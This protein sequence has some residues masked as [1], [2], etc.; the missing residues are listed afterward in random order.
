[1]YR[2][3]QKTNRIIYGAL[4]AAITFWVTVAF[5]G[6]GVDSHH[7]GIMLKTAAELAKGRVLYRDCVSQYG[8]VVHFL[9]SI[10]VSIF[11]AKLKVIIVQ[12]ALVD[13]VTSW[14]IFELIRKYV[15]Q[16]Y[17]FGVCV[18]ILA[19]SYMYFWIYHPWSN[20]YSVCFM[21]LCLFSTINY[22]EKRKG[23]DLIL[24]A[25]WAS[26]TFW[27]KLP[28]GMV[29]Y[30]ALAAAFFVIAVSKER[31]GD[32]KKRL[33]HMGVFLGTTICVWGL[34]VVYLAV[35]GA[36][37]ACWDQMVLF[38]LDFVQITIDKIVLKDAIL[39]KISFP[40]VSFLDSLFICL[41]K[42]GFSKS[43]R[44]YPI[45]ALLGFFIYAIRLLTS[46]GKEKKQRDNSAL[47]CFAI[48]A[49]ASWSQYYPVSCYRHRYWGMMLMIAFVSVVYY[50]ICKKYLKWPAINVAIFAFL[51]TLIPNIQLLNNN[52][53][54]GFEKLTESTN[55]VDN[56]YSVL[57][58]M[59]LSD[60]EYAFYE[61]F[62]NTLT[63][64]REYSGTEDMVNLS[65][66]Y[67][68]S[69]YSDNDYY[70]Y[71]KTLPDIMTYAVEKHAIVVT[72]LPLDDTIY[73]QYTLYASI[74]ITA[75]GDE[76]FTNS[77]LLRFYV[78]DTGR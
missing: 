3:N 74:P 78:Y 32:V 46:S 8:P 20:S 75:E 67:I 59:Y 35:N 49:V 25:I 64:V 23:Y 73:P 18:F 50:K 57:N 12:S 34:F 28:I 4:L 29:V 55:Q 44:A 26:L 31:E 33:K 40:H 70:L 21:V 77:N 69:C 19:S 54:S 16:L 38:A 10:A 15:P 37:K 39:A 63:E 66:Q 47:V 6:R 22:I 76:W 65:S 71:N 53:K 30:L 51:I 56:G 60:T 13:A 14:A 41:F 45:V 68:L 24:S 7:E 42:V 5:A 58:G 11:G 72:D 17:A 61:L 2:F 62:E 52:C 9:Q 1:M 48:F 43:E 27:C 36:L